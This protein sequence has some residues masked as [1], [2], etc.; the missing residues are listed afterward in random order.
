MELMV[1][2]SPQN[3]AATRTFLRTLNLLEINTEIAGQSAAVRKLTRIKLPDAI[4]LAT[5]QVQQCL[6]V[7]QNTR[8]FDPS[9]PTVR[10]PYVL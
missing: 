1:G 10:V 4:I 7:T 9:D 6:L 3:E 2:T 8:D 5:A